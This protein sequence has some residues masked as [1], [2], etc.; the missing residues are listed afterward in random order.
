MIDLRLARSL[1]VFLSLVSSFALGA[2]AAGGQ[3]S[4]PLV[5]LGPPIATLDEEFS[6]I[7]GLR[8][9]ASGALLVSDWFE[10][11]VYL[12][13]LASGSKTTRVPNGP[14]P[15]EVRLPGRLVPLPG[16]STLLQDEGN[17]RLTVLDPEGRVARS[18]RAERPGVLGARGRTA[19]G[20][21]LFAVPAWAAGTPLPDD[22]VR[23]V[24]WTPE[25]GDVRP[26][27]TVQGARRRRN[28]EPSR[29][30]RL[31]VV[32]HASQDAWEVGPNG[33]IVVVRGG[34][35][36]VEI[37]S[38]MRRLVAGPSYAYEPRP[39]TQADRRAFVEQF[40]A[41]SAM[42]GRGED[43]GLGHAP[44]A[45]PSEIARLVE[46]TEFADTHPYFSA[47][48]VLTDASGRVWVG[49]DGGEVGMAYE[50]FDDSGTRVAR[51]ELEGERSIGLVA[52][53][54]VYVVR[55]GELGLQSI[56]MYAVPA[57]S[58]GSSR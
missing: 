57:F 36:R 39:V 33:T 46:T 19:D 23:V 12:V 34:D 2:G 4:P 37:W 25:G 51:V 31:P 42:S 56:E 48:H 44:S 32:G 13:D 50:V 1:V 24:K 43:G 22:S 40:M 54:G 17:G 52:E 14:G 6:S 35:Y 18:I 8:E 20:G 16:D 28:Q 45:S 3:S 29:E 55:T 27:L 11:A 41:N 26:V 21:L 9:L 15:E 30:L 7:R 47:A 49:I 5:D 53:R 58:E 10:E 38:A